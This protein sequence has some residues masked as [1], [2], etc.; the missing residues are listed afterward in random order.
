M[1]TQTRTGNPEI[2]KLIEL[3]T[4]ANGF[5]MRQNVTT[6]TTNMSGRPARTQLELPATRTI[7]REMSVSNIRVIPS[8]PARFAIPV[9]YRRADTPEV[10]KTAADVLEMRPAGR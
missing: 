7:T 2:D 8:N 1:A 5:A 9:S 3:E 6:V 10:P 4:A